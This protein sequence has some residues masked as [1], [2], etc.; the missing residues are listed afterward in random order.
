MHDYE[1]N[2]EL[3]ITPL[4]DVMLV[5]LAIMMVIAPTFIYEEQIRLP[6]GSNSQKFEN[7]EPINITL[8]KN[9]KI[10][11]NKKEV[12]FKD[13]ANDFMLASP[14][15]SKETTIAIGADKSVTYDKVIYILR[16]VKTAGFAKI[17]LLTDG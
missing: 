6:Q 5:L 13:F 3:N 17:S 14:S 10:K 4:V 12:D 9:N 2:P 8:L 7:K 15:F 11:I 1:S 16:T